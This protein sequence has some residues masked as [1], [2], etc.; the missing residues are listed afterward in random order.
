MNLPTRSADAVGSW[1][2]LP[3][4]TRGHTG[5]GADRVATAGAARLRADRRVLRAWNWPMSRKRAARLA[6][7]VRRHLRA[8]GLAVSVWVANY[9]G[10]TMLC[11]DARDAKSRRELLGGYFVPHIE[12]WHRFGPDGV[13]DSV[14]AANRKGRA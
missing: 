5:R 13:C 4:P 10:V 3:T 7:A 11:L 14:R 6:P 12:A 9:Y 8:H 2:R 1:A